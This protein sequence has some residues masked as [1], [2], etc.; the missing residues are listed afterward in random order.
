MKIGIIGG[1][2]TGLGTAFYLLESGLKNSEIVL[3]EKDDSVGGLASGFKASGW[4]WYLDKLVHHWFSTDKYVLELVKK[5]GLGNKII[6]KNTKSSCFKDGK[7]A[8]LDSPLSLLKFP[9]ISFLSRLRTGIVMAYF[10]LQGKEGWKKY[11]GETSYN[12]IKKLM[13][14]ESFNVIWKPLFEGKFGKYAEKVN[15][16]WIW[17]RI[18][19]RTKSLVYVEGGFQNF[20]NKVKEYLKNKGIKIILNS[21]VKKVEK[22]HRKFIIHLKNRK[23]TKLEFDIVVM[24]VPFSVFLNVVEGLPKDYVKEISKLKSI[25]S[26]YLILETEKS[27]IGDTYWLNINESKFP[28]MLLADHTNFVG[29]KGYGGRH[30][31]YVGKYLENSDK[32]YKLNKQQLLKKIEPYLKQVNKE[33]SLKWIKRSWLFRFDNSQPLLPLNYSKKMPSIK[34][35]I[36]NLYVANMFHIYP[37]DRGTNN[38]LEIAKKVTKIVENTLV[39]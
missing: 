17:G 18:N 11:E 37:W 33:F 19:P 23:V 24:A 2:F 4:D 10:R 21:E 14:L 36:K 25:A 31:T 9:F 5:V 6:I 39:C 7:I 29:K 38:A 26:Q 12:L 32:L 28:F 16:A 22:K 3:I 15:G 8:E 30:I 1:G 20:L 35:P 13:G 34:T 27:I